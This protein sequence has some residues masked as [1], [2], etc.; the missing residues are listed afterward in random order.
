MVEE[1]FMGI[2]FMNIGTEYA[3]MK[4]KCLWKEIRM[5]IH[6]HPILKFPK[7]KELEFTFNGGVYRGLEGDTIASALHAQGVKVLSHSH[8]HDR[9]RGFYCAIG[10]CSSCLMTVNKIANVRICTEL[11]QEGMV[12]ESQS[13]KGSLI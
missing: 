9:P 4:G 13:G 10:N 11:L 1:I 2:I 3:S 7:T 8:K 12:V 6:E 5:R